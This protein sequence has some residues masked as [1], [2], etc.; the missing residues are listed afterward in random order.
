MM[1]VGIFLFLG[2]CLSLGLVGIP[3]AVGVSIF[4]AGCLVDLKWA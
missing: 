3:I 4:A 1:L 2:G